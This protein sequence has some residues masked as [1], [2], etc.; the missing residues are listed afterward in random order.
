MSG[1]T[2]NFAAALAD[3]LWVL[4]W[5]LRAGDSG[6][7]AA[8][9]VWDQATG[10]GVRVAVMDQGIDAGHPDLAEAY[11][12]GWSLDGGSAQPRTATDSHGTAVAGIV[13]ARAND[14]GM[15]GV[16][17]GADLVSLYNPLSTATMTDTVA[18]GWRY[19]AGAGDADVVNNS[20][21]YSALMLHSADF[22]FLD[23]H[24]L[25][26]QQRFGIDYGDFTAIGAALADL[27]EQGRGGLGATVVMAAGNANLEGDDVNLH[28]TQASRHTVTVSATGR[29]GDAALFSTHGAAVL[30]SAPGQGVVSTDRV[31]EAGY[32]GDDFTQVSGT[33]FSAPMV[34]GTV[35]LML[36]A[37]AGLGWRDVQDI[38]AFSARQ[39]DAGDPGWQVNGAGLA[40]SHE[41]GFGMVDAR[42][43]VRLAAS[44]TG[45]AATSAN[46]LHLSAELAA[47]AAI[48][49]GGVGVL[50]QA[51]SFADDI[52]LDAVSLDIDLPHDRVGDLTITLVSPSGT[53][54]RLLDRPGLG[55]TDAPGDHLVW[56]F[57]AMAFRE[58]HG[59]GTWTLRIADAIAGLSGSLQSWTLHLYGDAPGANDR[60]VFTDSFAGSAAPLVDEAGVD[61]LNAAALSGDAAIDLRPGSESQL[62]AGS[63]WLDQ[64]A[65]IEHAVA[66]DGDDMLTGNDGANWL[67]GG[68]GDDTLAGGAG[69]DT[70]DGGDGRDAVQLGAT[71][72]A[73][74][75]LRTGVAEGNRLVA[76]EDLLGGDF[77]DWLVGDGDAN[78]LDGFAGA[79]TLIGAAG[80]DELAG[81][82]GGDNLR[83]TR[84]ADTL[85]GGVGDD[86]LYGGADD[87]RVDGGDG[88]DLAAG[89]SGD[90][91]VT[92]GAGDDLLRGQ[93]GDD[94]LFGD[95]GDDHLVG[96]AGADLLV[97]GDGDDT[98]V[99]GPSDD[100]LTGGAGADVFVFGDNQAAD[101]VSD[102]Q[103][104]VDRLQLPGVGFEIIDGPEGAIVT[105][106]EMGT[107]VTLKDIDP[108]Q[109]SAGDFILG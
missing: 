76:V 78:R 87:D 85:D 53:E 57:G 70:L 65:M 3:P 1:P 47:P 72:G 36:E 63:L 106:G 81:G 20:W 77:G 39:T 38:L 102:F 100:W 67:L 91:T 5:Y 4:Q 12:G 62:A 97:G 48:P 35:A 8:A 66:G 79:D 21:S 30:V 19:A 14:D 7:I 88:I 82:A 68:A 51:V 92:G 29:D 15:V 2:Q 13:A 55:Q 108:G 45:P 101:T 52:V 50:E 37:N 96:H 56:T 11:A 60:Y 25:A 43:A 46:E 42:A 9:S 69:G 10:A 32:S 40:Y 28:G 6:G 80:D 64:T 104:G 61:W 84:G 54:A 98:L 23:D 99:G 109:L 33:S 24:R 74:A 41:Y 44:W 89:N 59:A 34:S 58:E 17:P 86:M 31:G 95:A 49:D 18:A 75:D 16:A 73:V 27:V 71:S 107:V 94:W 105:W 103:P 90:D 22:A 93:G 83:G 26:D